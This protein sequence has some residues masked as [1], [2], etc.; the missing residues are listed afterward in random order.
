MDWIKV[1][2]S[3]ALYEYADLSDAQFR[4]WI[5]A[6]CLVAVMEKIPNEEDLARQINSRTLKS[7]REKLALHRTPLEL[8]LKKVLEDVEYTIN[9]KAKNRSKIAEYRHKKAKCNPLHDTVTETVTLPD[10]IREDK[11]R[12][13]NYITPRYYFST[14]YEKKFKTP[15]VPHEGKDYQTFADLKKTLKDEQVISLIDKFFDYKDDFVEKAGYT[16]QVFV[17]VI[18]KLQLPQKTKTRIPY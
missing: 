4:A 12:E 10:K 16:V 11:I 9:L 6:M 13:D 1:K 14:A 5:K 8:I 2:T 15:Y 17:S 18:N 7:L 3:H